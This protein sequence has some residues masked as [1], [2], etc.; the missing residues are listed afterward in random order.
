MC[1]VYL[2][3][4]AVAILITGFGLVWFFR[5]DLRDWMESPRDHFLE[6][7]RRFPRVVRRDAAR[8]GAPG[9]RAERAASPVQ[10]LPS[11]NSPPAGVG[12]AATSG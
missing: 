5:P 4:A 9:A 8:S 3:L 10:R 7:Q 11:R 1:G 6:L 12:T 2:T